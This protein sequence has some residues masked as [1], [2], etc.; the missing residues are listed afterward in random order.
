MNTTA[1]TFN[2]SPRDCDLT[3]CI[4]DSIRRDPSLSLEPIIV[5]V[6]NSRAV[7]RGTVSS[8]AAR[9]AARNAAEKVQ[10]ITSVT[11]ELTV[12]VPPHLRR[13]D[14]E[15]RDAVLDALKWRAYLPC[16]AVTVTVRDGCVTLSGRVDWSYQRKLAEKVLLPLLGITSI[17]NELRVSDRQIQ[18]E[19]SARIRARLR[20]AAERQADA[21]KVKVRGGVATLRGQL[22]VVDERAFVI[23]AAQS[24]PEVRQVSDELRSRSRPR[25]RRRTSVSNALDRQKLGIK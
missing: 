24:H 12:S 17:S 16:G 25:M 23:S 14:T 13:S 22:P 19:V 8:C 7:L 11:S 5:D 4:V 18:M 1:A 15:I 9:V 20:L 21:I 10:G 3:N 6:R 2:I